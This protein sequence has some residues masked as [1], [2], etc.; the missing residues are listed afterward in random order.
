MRTE[1]RCYAAGLESKKIFVNT[2]EY[3]I[4]LR[5][6]EEG[7]ADEMAGR[8][9]EENRLHLATLDSSS[10]NTLPTLETT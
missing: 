1:A 8:E 2:Q 3:P 7:I 10:A 5:F 6:H 9:K 4:C